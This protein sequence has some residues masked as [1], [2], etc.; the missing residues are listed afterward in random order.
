MNTTR[1]L[2]LKMI[3]SQLPIYCPVGFCGVNPK[4]AFLGLIMSH[5][6]MLICCLFWFNIFHLD[7]KGIPIRC[8][9]IMDFLSFFFFLFILLDFV[10]RK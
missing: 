4:N 3:L 2:A 1:S 5:T 8:L 9:K 6:F 7:G 10:L